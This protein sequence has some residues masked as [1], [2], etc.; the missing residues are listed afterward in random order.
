MHQQ[1]KDFLQ[2]TKNKHPQFFENISVLEFGSMNWNG[3]PRDFFSNC[4]YIGVDMA[5][6]TDVDVVCLA[7][8]YN[9]AKRFEVIITTEMLE[10]DKEWKESLENSVRLLKNGG[11]LIGTAANINREPHCL[12]IGYYRNMSREDIVSVL[13]EKIYIEE[14]ENK[15]DIRFIYIKNDRQPRE[16]EK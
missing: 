8:R 5:D 15:D 2:Q 9:T 10:H 14:D 1:V 11:I 7:S 4:E 12:E 6:G 3:T 16:T 13:G